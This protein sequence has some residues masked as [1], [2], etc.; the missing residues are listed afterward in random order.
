MLAAWALAAQAVM[1]SPE[2]AVRSQARPH[3]RRLHR[4]RPPPSPPRRRSNASPSLEATWSRLRWRMARDSAATRNWRD[5]GRRRAAPPPSACSAAES[6]PNSSGTCIEPPPAPFPDAGAATI[7][8]ASGA[9]CTEAPLN[10]YWD[11]ETEA[12]E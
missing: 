1:A 11:S 6:R 4:P 3:L 8:P 9:N 7:A 5:S 2:A 10:L 12:E